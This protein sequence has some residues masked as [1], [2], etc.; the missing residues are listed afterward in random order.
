MQQ[1]EPN[2]ESFLDHNHPP[3][4]DD[5][6]SLL[7]ELSSVE[8]ELRSVELRLEELR[9]RQAH[10]RSAISPLR[11]F[12]SE[13]LAELF[14][15]CLPPI[16]DEGGRER[17]LVLRSVCRA[18]REAA[19]STPEL[20][21][22]IKLRVYIPN[23]RYWG[24]GDT[25]IVPWR[26]LRSWFGRA[27]STP[28]WLL[29]HF[30]IDEKIL[31]G[32]GGRRHS[33]PDV[34]EDV[35]RIFQLLE[36]DRGWKG[37]SITYGRICPAPFRN[38]FLDMM[39]TISLAPVGTT[40]SLSPW[41]NLRSLHIPLT[42]RGPQRPEVILWAN[43]LESLSPH[44]SDLTLTMTSRLAL[45]IVG[46]DLP[47]LKKLK[48][49]E[50]DP[51]MTR[52]WQTEA[53]LE[54]ERF[55]HDGVEELVI[56]STMHPLEPLGFLT[57]P[58]LRSLACH[59][60]GRERSSR[61]NSVPPDP[62]TPIVSF[63]ARS[64]DSLRTLDLAYA[65]LRL[66]PQD[67]VQMWLAISRC[68]SLRYLSVE[69]DKFHV[70]LPS[71]DPHSALSIPFPAIRRI[72]LYEHSA[73]ID[74]RAIARYFAYRQSRIDSSPSAA[75]NGSNESVAG[76]EPAELQMGC[77]RAEIVITFIGL[78]CREGKPSR[79]QEL[80]WDLESDVEYANALR[81]LTDLGVRIVV[82]DD[83]RNEYARL[84]FLDS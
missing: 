26:E 63:L 9:A 71:P 60:K 18:W 66:E 64:G 8:D 45:H 16:L 28:L 43:N 4:D 27:G 39:E 49:D 20:W 13:L 35:R 57:L 2:L 72:A 74:L 12:P 23:A 5:V 36:E 56:S 61:G 32:G 75:V 69:C 53:D 82:E 83:G 19:F 38:L 29:V 81:E 79:A 70:L 24:K 65:G 31:T 55:V 84:T 59:R 67:E 76:G 80:Q 22:G 68:R 78:S 40:T 52:Y 44:L 62:V 34:L 58:S 11:R 46:G 51:A 3:G 48:I 41:R 7:K 17:F 25:S 1:L 14:R 21:A 42:H 6:R 77:R 73:T 37:I 47:N 10:L 33:N 30:E 15:A 50:T 54:R